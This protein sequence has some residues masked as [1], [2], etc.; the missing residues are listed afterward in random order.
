MFGEDLVTYTW[1]AL[2]DECDA[3]GYTVADEVYNYELQKN[4]WGV[5]DGIMGRELFAL[6]KLDVPMP[7]VS[8]PEL[9]MHHNHGVVVRLHRS[10]KLV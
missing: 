10:L 2:E 1:A 6:V 5:V 3:Q 7:L 4:L 9:V 8:F